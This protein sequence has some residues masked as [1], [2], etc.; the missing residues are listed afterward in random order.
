MQIATLPSAA[1]SAR[2]PGIF[3]PLKQMSVSVPGCIINHLEV[4]KSPFL[5][6][7][8]FACLQ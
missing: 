7:I 4:L 6:N 5:V 2:A 3:I 8:D 1:S